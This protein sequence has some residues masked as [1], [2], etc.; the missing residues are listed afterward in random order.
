[1][2]NDVTI[3]ELDHPNKNSQNGTFLIVNGLSSTV[4]HQSIVDQINEIMCM[5]QFF[6][7]RQLLCVK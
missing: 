7:E 1:V 5:M 3:D 4:E 2:V 6:C